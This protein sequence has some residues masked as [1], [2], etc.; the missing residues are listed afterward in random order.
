M[1]PEAFKG[2]AGDIVRAI[3]PTTEADPVAV[4][5]SLLVLVCSLV[6]RGPHLMI[7]DTRHGENLFATLVGDTSTARKGTS[8]A[9]PRRHMELVDPVWTNERIQGA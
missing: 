2:L 5:V 3:D 4:L 7:G 1:A 6:T 8:L 9:D